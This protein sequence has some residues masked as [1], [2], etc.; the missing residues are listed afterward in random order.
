[1]QPKNKVVLFDLDGTLINSALSFHKIVNSLKAT[2]NQDSVDFEVVRKYSSR[3]ATLV[4][5]SAF[6]DA[7]DEKIAL[8]K[9]SFLEQY[10]EHMTSNITKY[11]GVD[12]LLKYLNN[13]QIPWGIVT[14]KSAIYTRPIIEELNWDKATE[15]IICPEDLNEVKP[16]PEGVF[17]GL[18]IL[19][20]A[21]EK[22]YYVG[23]HERDIETAKNA[24]VISIA[25]T[26]GYH[27]ND[28]K[29][30]NADHIVD[31]PADIIEI[32]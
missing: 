5:K 11:D 31:S 9:N 10:K 2:E 6:P 25:C 28:P 4:L 24:G 19:N 14:N 13:N 32:I 12:E 26:Y 16:S 18:N 17:K 20:G 27:E 8:L 30:W 7:S 22:S 3:G 1:M 21:I 15:A 23:D 29:N